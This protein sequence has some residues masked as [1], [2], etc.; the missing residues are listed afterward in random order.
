[1]HRRN[2]IKATGLTAA[3]AAVLSGETL[4]AQTPGEAKIKIG[5]IGVGARGLNHLDLLLRRDDVELMA[6]CDIDAITLASAKAM[7]TKSGKKMP[8]IFTGDTNAWKKMPEIKGGLD[9]VLIVTPWELHKEMIITSLEAGIKYIGTE[10][11][12]GITLQDHW[13]VIHAAE[14]HK[15]HVMMLENVCYRRDVMAVLN[16]VRQGLFGE[17]IH[18]QGGYQHD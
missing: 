7:I 15:A 14:K 6:I 18:L 17:I 11:I 16:M 8:Q 12:L 1:M 2:F 10:V 3:S 9:A 5:I 13:D 4:F